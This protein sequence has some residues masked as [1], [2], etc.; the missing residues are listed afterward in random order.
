M[1]T[2]ENKKSLIYLDNYLS[3]LMIKCHEF[4]PNYKNTKKINEEKP[5]IPKFSE[6]N[7]IYKNSYN[8]QQLKYF[9]KF[10]KLKI[11][12]NK[13]ELLNRLFSFIRLSYFAV[14]LQKIFRGKLIRKYLLLHGPA[15]LSKKLCTNVTDFYTMDEIKNIPYNQFFSFKDKDNFI[16]GFD[17]I[18]FHNLIVK[19]TKEPKNPY[20]RYT[21]S[22]ETISNMKTLI[23][24]SKLLKI[25]IDID[26]SNEIVGE[27]TTEQRVRDLFIN[28]DSYGHYS[29]PEWFLS[30]NRN[31]LIKLLVEIRDIW[32]YRADLSIS[33]KRA[34]CPHRGEP[35]RFLNLGYIT[36]EVNIEIL[37]K[38]IIEVLEKIVNTGIN[39]ESRTL[40]AYYVLGALTLV[41]E[42]AAASI[43]WLYSAF[44]IF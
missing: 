20:N 19:S 13:N 11:S 15:I 36:N 39:E 9:A 16:Y 2:E 10:F 31:K 37:R 1:T 41:N 4:I 40:G 22:T 29:N 25:D 33:T 17:I 7:M 12:G 6:F 21:I 27:R 18:S 8:I 35:F 26:I 23:K 42:N 44:V 3:S 38:E 32:N 43:P 28:I 14:K 24:L 34:I 30:L 5:N